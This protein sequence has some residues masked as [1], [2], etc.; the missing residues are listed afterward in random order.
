M[1]AAPPEGFEKIVEGQA[2]VL[3]RP[4]E[5]FYNPVQAL[6]PSGLVPSIVWQVVN[7]DLS[8]MM[9]RLYDKLRREE[10]DKLGPGAR[11]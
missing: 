7:R 1:D 5:S 10:I 3:Y 2:S 9:L 6:L 8:V 11:R 4:G